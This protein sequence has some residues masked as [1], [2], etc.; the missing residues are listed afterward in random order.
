MLRLK[1]LLSVGLLFLG[2][3]CEG[4]ATTPIGSTAQPLALTD[5]VPLDATE[6]IGPAYAATGAVAGASS[7]DGYLLSWCQDNQRV[8]A[9]FS[10]DG[11]QLDA[12]AQLVFETCDLSQVAFSDS[13]YL[14]V[15]SEG[16]DLQARPMDAEGRLGA[17]Q[18][19]AFDFASELQLVGGTHGSL[20]GYNTIDDRFAVRRLTGDGLPLDR[21]LAGTTGRAW[22][23]S[24]GDDY[25]VA[26]RTDDKLVAKRCPGDQEL[27]LS[28]STDLGALPPLLKPSIALAFVGDRLVV[29]R[30]GSGVELFDSDL[31]PLGAI[32]GLSGVIPAEHVE[33]D[34]YGSSDTRETAQTITAIGDRALIAWADADSTLKA[35]IFD[36]ALGK[37][38][39][40]PFTVTDARGFSWTANWTVTGVGEKRLMVWD[41]WHSDRPGMWMASIDSSGQLGEEQSL[42]QGP[43]QQ[44]LQAAVATNQGSL[45]TWTEWRDG[46]YHG[47][48][49]GVS[50]AGQPQGES[51]EVFT[52]AGGQ[53]YSHLAWSGT[54]ALAVWIRPH[55]GTSWQLLDASGEPVGEVVAEPNRLALG[56]ASTGASFVL[57]E[58]GVDSN[59]RLTLLGLD[60]REEKQVGMGAHSPPNCAIGA[61][62]TYMVACVEAELVKVLRFDDELNVVGSAVSR[63]PDELRYTTSDSVQL[64]RGAGDYLL[65]FNA[66]GVS[67]AARL[68]AQGGLLGQVLELGQP[69][70][71]SAAFDGSG[72][73]LAVG[74]ELVR[75]SGNGDP[76]VLQL[77]G[78]T[79]DSPVLLTPT[80][81]GDTQLFYQSGDEVS[82]VVTSRLSGNGAK[83][84][85]AS[86]ETT[87][88]G[89][90]CS[91]RPARRQPKGAAWIAFGVLAMA[92]GWRRRRALRAS[93]RRS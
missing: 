27:D 51:H 39:T 14:I 54:H 71:V 16:R 5:A 10:N 59:L 85:C 81:N 18:T 23:A 63:L 86:G 88:G 65:T 44:F 7:P 57:T 70:S 31:S 8:A 24:A 75:L 45:A 92:V 61:D 35:T 17:T 60:G 76:E 40:D 30:A 79:E 62:D 56:V 15:Q 28:S 46:T 19:L 55:Q 1:H 43:N 25:L 48:A 36:P 68:D 80:C 11:G 33:Y 37:T 20:L 6:V 42:L 29:S 73:V 3:G 64:T 53:A 32:Q 34:P 2:A 74:T 38:V 49:R 93:H 78:A 69:S 84:A 21:T 52:S 22:L 41:A 12:P 66:F 77:E 82:R 9:R 13:G 72:W 26:W 90:G 67:Y 89:G 91:V 58:W 87:P 4:S 83:G 50:P 47:F